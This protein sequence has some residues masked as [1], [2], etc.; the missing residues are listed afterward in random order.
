MN[1]GRIPIKAMDMSYQSSEQKKPLLLNTNA[2]WGIISSIHEEHAW[3]R[4]S[5]PPQEDVSKSRSRDLVIASRHQEVNTSFIEISVTNSSFNLVRSD[6][7][8][9]SEELNLTWLL[10]AWSVGKAWSRHPQTI[11]SNKSPTS[12]SRYIHDTCLREIGSHNCFIVQ[13][14]GIIENPWSVT[15]V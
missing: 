12:N 3:G 6:D 8:P 5:G 1:V 14:Q 9:A 7:E 2:H 15:L 10:T 11:S 4:C 13:E